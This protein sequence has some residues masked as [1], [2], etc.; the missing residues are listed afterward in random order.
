MSRSAG[1]RQ[2]PNRS[3]TVDVSVSSVSWRQSHAK[4]SASGASW[5]RLPFCGISQRG[6]RGTLD[7]GA[8]RRAWAC[9]STPSSTSQPCLVWFLQRSNRISN[10]ARKG[11]GGGG[12][13]ADPGCALDVCLKRDFVCGKKGQQVRNAAASAAGTEGARLFSYV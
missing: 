5:R 13:S 2:P 6:H 7:K 10:S 12:G 1:R 11:K 4:S 3:A 9:P 8:W